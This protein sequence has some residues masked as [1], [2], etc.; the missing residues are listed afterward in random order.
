MQ[1]L[2]C[3]ERQPHTLRT[4]ENRG[5]FHLKHIYIYQLPQRGAFWVLE[6][7]LS[8]GCFMNTPL[9]IMWE[10]LKN[11]IQNLCPLW[12]SKQE[13]K[14]SHGN[15]DNINILLG[16][17]ITTWLLISWLLFQNIH[18]LLLRAAASGH[19]Q[20]SFS[21]GQRRCHRHVLTPSNPKSTVEHSRMFKCKTHTLHID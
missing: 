15:T 3:W 4:S 20:L 12:K 1:L 21:A 2:S 7:D 5:K 18:P 17:W 9:T 16:E 11:P 8:K 10:R 14:Q 19:H 13:M 6:Y